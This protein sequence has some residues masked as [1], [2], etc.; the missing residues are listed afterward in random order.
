MFYFTCRG[1]LGRRAFGAASES[2]ASVPGLRGV[3]LR[4]AFYRRTLAQCGEDVYFGWQSV[5]SMPEAR[6][7]DR[8]YIGRF[9][10]LGFAHIGDE[11]MLADHVQLLSGGQEHAHG[12]V[13]KSIQSQGQCFRQVRIGQGAWIGAGAIVM[14]DVGEHAI[15]GAGAVVNQPIPAYSVAVGVPARVIKSRTPMSPPLQVEV[16][17][18]A[19]PEAMVVGR[20]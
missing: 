2:I 14:A 9:C 16:R 19:L 8:A 3:Y 15:I 1:F 6:V 4:Q 17:Q 12:S 10:S 20:S 11:V 13:D 7:G 18:P 5:F